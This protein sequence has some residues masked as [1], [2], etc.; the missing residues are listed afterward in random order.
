MQSLGKVIAKR[1]AHDTENLES[2]DVHN[3]EDSERHDGANLDVQLDQAATSLPVEAAPG[4]EEADA[5][6]SAK[7]LAN[8]LGLPGPTVSRI[9]N[10]LLDVREE[11][12]WAQ[13]LGVELPEFRQAWERGRR[14]RLYA[15]EARLA[16]CAQAISANPD[17]AIQAR[18]RTKRSELLTDAGRYAE[19]AREAEAAIAAAPFGNVRSREFR[20]SAIPSP[21]STFMKWMPAVAFAGSGK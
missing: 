20:A 18:L 17:K 14:A 13:L 11:E 9:E 12:R 3:N 15:A 7:Q 10:G 21:C 1:R 8:E 19:A 4:I 5:A 16:A 6:G 2:Q